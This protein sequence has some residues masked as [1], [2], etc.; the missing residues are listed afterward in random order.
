MSTTRAKSFTLIEPLVSIVIIA[1]VAIAFFSTLMTSFSYFRRVLELRT[2][3]L[4]LQDQV[5]KTRELKF[6]D[7]NNLGGGF[8][9]ASTTPLHNVTGTI[10]KSS[11]TGDG[12]SLKIT[13][14]L[15]WTAFDGRAEEKTIVT[16]MTDHGIN[17]K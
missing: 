11:Y 12:K 15:N 4:L 3:S 14:M 13:F 2:A 1:F 16:I 9:P 6:S 5:G 17:K 7:I 8:T 10:S